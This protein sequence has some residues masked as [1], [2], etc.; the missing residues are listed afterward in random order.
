MYELADHLKEADFLSRQRG[1]PYTEVGTFHMSRLGRIVSDRFDALPVSQDDVRK[2]LATFPALMRDELGKDPH[3]RGVNSTFS[4]GVCAELLRRC[5]GFRSV[6][7][8]SSRVFVAWLSY[9]LG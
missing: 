5:E 7:Q 8:H 9:R 2:P 3:A 1:V 6:L 4:L